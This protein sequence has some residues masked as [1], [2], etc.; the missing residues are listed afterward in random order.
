MN[1]SNPDFCQNF[2][3]LFRWIN[4]GLD[5][6]VIQWCKAEQDKQIHSIPSQAERYEP[7]QL[8]F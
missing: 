2:R 8:I 5:I 1:L 4:K 3:I 6:F 7:R